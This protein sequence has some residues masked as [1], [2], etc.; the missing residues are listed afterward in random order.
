MFFLPKRQEKS[1]TFKTKSKS[2]N[3]PLLSRALQL[4]NFNIEL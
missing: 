3:L 1:E 2:A 4:R